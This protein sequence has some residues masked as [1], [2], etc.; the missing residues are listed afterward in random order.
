MFIIVVGEKLISIT[1]GGVTLA[2]E[3]LPLPPTVTDLIDSHDKLLQALDHHL[4]Q[5]IGGQTTK[6]DRQ[7]SLNEQ[8]IVRL[9][10]LRQSIEQSLI[11]SGS[12]EWK[13]LATNI[14]SFGPR[15]YGPNMLVNGVTGYNRPSVWQLLDKTA[16]AT[17]SQCI[18]EFDSAIVNGFQLATLIGPMC[19]EPMRGVAFVVR[20]WDMT[21]APP[22][23]LPGM[24][25]HSLR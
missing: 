21:V 20:K 10:S 11:A 18:R 3:A 8:C 13:S 1:R 9:N 12:E 24:L 14:W 15:K 2:I 23:N 5:S 25:N 16:S 4:S 17:E 22:S 19:A 6:Y 7:T